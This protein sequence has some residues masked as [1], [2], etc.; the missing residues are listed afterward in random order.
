M[1]PCMLCACFFVCMFRINIRFLCSYT[2][3]VSV[4]CNQTGRLFKVKGT[5]L[6]RGDDGNMSMKDLAE[7]SQLLMK[8]NKKEY[9][10]TVL[11]DTLTPKETLKEVQ[12]NG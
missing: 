6:S 8:M 1:L 9:P 10:V 3:K 5:S 12:V 11:K 4:K 7:G 2:E